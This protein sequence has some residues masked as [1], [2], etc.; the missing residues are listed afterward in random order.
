MTDLTPTISGGGCFIYNEK[1]QLRLFIFETIAGKG[2]PHHQQDPV[3][4]SD[5][6]HQQ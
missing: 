2:Q 4:H 5:W 6:Y 1:M 3:V